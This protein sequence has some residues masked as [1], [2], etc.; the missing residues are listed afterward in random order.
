[1][2]KSFMASV[3]YIYCVYVSVSG[4]WE[5]IVCVCWFLFVDVFRG[6]VNF[7]FI[8]YFFS[9]NSAALW[10][11][12]MILALGARG[13]GFDLRQGPN[14]F[15]FSW[16]SLPTFQFTDA[17]NF[18]TDITD[19]LRISPPTLRISLRI[20]H[21]LLFVFSVADLGIRPNQH[22]TY[23]YSSWILSL[24]SWRIREI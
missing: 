13:P 19:T 7:N 4:D 10:S 15:T 8:L 24:E 9:P 14:F 3:L 20:S 22:L 18:S 21:E 17:R 11:S 5:C 12:G 23:T 6:V 1:M 2:S 16:Q